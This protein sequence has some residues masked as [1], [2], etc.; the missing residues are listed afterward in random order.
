[1]IGKKTS[2]FDNYSGDIEWTNEEYH[3][4]RNQ[5]QNLFK[6]NIIN[7][8]ISFEVNIPDL[9]SNIIHEIK[10][11]YVIRKKELLQ[12][13]MKESYLNSGLPI[14]EN[15][16]WKL[17]WI[18]GSSKLASISEP[19]LQVDLHCLN[20]D[21]ANSKSLVNFEMGLEQLDKFINDLENAKA[22]LNT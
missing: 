2:S 1:M 22:L 9:P 5:I 16:D 17:K 14:V 4:A 15:I 11:C 3:K 13:V 8:N 7:N 20:K 19:I 21:A 10:N 18:N 6:S 12:F